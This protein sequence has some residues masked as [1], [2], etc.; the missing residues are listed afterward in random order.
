[1]SGVV[2]DGFGSI[3]APTACCGLVGLKPTR[4]RNTMALYMGE[5]LNGLSTEHAVSLSVRDSAEIL[6]ATR[7][8]GA[9][10]PYSRTTAGSPF[11]G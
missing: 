2:S 8:L 3:R 6:D 10:D 4:G 5:G 9:G 1:M 7:D 11:P